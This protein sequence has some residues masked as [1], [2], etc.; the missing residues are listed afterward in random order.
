MRSVRWNTES[1]DLVDLA[2]SMK[3]WCSMALGA[4]KDR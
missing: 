2:V 1:D 4:A 3:L